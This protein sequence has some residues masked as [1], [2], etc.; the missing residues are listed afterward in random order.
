M[1]AS[2]ATSSALSST[3]SFVRLVYAG[4]QVDE[5]VDG[6]DDDFGGDENDDDPFEIFA[7]LILS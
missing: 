3:T 2:T 1:R 7:C 4:I 5:D 6:C